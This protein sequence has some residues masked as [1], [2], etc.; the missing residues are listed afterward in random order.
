MNRGSRISTAA[1]GVIFGF[2]LTSCGFGNYATIHQALLL[3]SGYLYAVFAS[4][5]VVSTLGL[6]LLRR[7]GTTKFGGP[8]RL[9]HHP[10]RP[11]HVYGA[12]IF[13][14]GFGISGAC[15][16]SAVAMVGTG[17]MGG[18][19]VLGGIIGGLWLRGRTESSAAPELAL[20][21]L[22][23]QA[24]QPT[25]PA[26]QP[27]WPASQPGKPAG[28]LGK[29]GHPGIGPAADA[30]AGDSPDAAPAAAVKEASDAAAS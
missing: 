13:G 5:M 10:A 3:R 16:G 11:R 23:R 9:P 15:P 22:G 6:I 26:S 1:V 12:A 17:G 8:L 29:L 19:L 28:Q 7:A 21:Q 4:A 14:A 24:S 2:L 27:T 20:G 30:V 18:L 25:W